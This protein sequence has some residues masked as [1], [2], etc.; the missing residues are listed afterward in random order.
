MQTI[1][2]HCTANSCWMVIHG[3]VY[4]IPSS[5]LN[6]HPGGK[7]ILLKWAGKEATRA[8][9]DAGHSAEAVKSMEKFCIGRLDDV[10]RRLDGFPLP[11]LS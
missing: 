5:Y 11:F 2:T 8:F 7:A 1:A 4:S 10:S 6:E 9:D 3:R